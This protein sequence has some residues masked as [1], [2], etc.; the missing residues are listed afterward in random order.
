[1]D[2][3]EVTEHTPLVAVMNRLRDL[4]VRASI[5]AFV[6]PSKKWINPHPAQID[7]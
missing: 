1:V 7:P 3:S 4:L 6:S 5:C 2:I